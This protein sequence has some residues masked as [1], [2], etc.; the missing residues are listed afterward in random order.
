MVK[1]IRY[2]RFY[3]IRTGSIYL[4]KVN[5]FLNFLG[6]ILAFSENVGRVLEEI[7]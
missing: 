2:P 6:P 5:Y 4:Q 3:N 7:R 1:I